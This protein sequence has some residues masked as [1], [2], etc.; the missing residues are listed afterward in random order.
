[1]VQIGTDGGLLQ[2]PTARASIECAPSERLDVIVDFSAVPVG[3]KVV[4]LNLNDNGSKGSVMRFEVDRKEKDNSVVPPFLTLWEELPEDRAV[5][6]REFVLNRQAVDGAL[7]WTINGQPYP[8]SAPMAYPKLDTVERWRFVNPTNHPHPMHVHLVQFQ[9]VNLDGEPQ[10]PAEHGWKDTVLVAAGGEAT[11]IARFSG[12]TGR[13]VF[14]CHNL[15][16]E[17]FAMM[18]EFEV[19]P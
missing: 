11:I 7:T 17:D 8:Q 3:E 19:V 5:I 10:D 14:H 6:T 16:H 12:Y 13:Y 2:R 1:L 9:V 18:A 4:L 15:E